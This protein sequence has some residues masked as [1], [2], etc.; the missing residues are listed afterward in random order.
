MFSFNCP[1]LHKQPPPLAYNYDRHQLLATE[2]RSRGLSPVPISLGTSNLLI[3]LH[4]QQLIRRLPV[5]TPGNFLANGPPPWTWEYQNGVTA[6]LIQK[7]RVSAK[8]SPDILAR[9][10][11]ENRSL[12]ERNIGTLR[13]SVAAS[14]NLSLTNCPSDLGLLFLRELDIYHAKVLFK[15]FDLLCTAQCSLAAH[16]NLRRHGSTD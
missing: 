9:E 1:E 14:C 10:T 8:S 12:K 6:R 11:L 4:C 15:V 3:P 2:L 13:I 7:D 16:H 5:P